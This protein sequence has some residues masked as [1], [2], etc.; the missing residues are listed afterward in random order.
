MKIFSPLFLIFY[1]C[2]ASI[3]QAQSWVKLDSMPGGGLAVFFVNSD[4]G[5]SSYGNKILKTIDGGYNWTSQQTGLTWPYNIQSINFTS[6][7]TGFA[8]G[9]FYNGLTYLGI[10]IKTVNGGQNW[11][12]LY[13]S[14]PGPLRVITCIS[15]LKCFTGGGGLYGGDFFE[16]I[17]LR[18]IDGGVTWVG[19]T[20]PQATS[21]INFPT[22]QVGYALGTFPL[23]TASNFCKSTDGG[24][25]WVCQNLSIQLAPPSF[26]FISLNFTSASIGYAVG[27]NG[28]I[29]KTIN[30]GT[31]WTV[32]NSGTT[33][34]LYSVCFVSPNTGFISGLDGAVLN[35]LNGGTTWVLQPSLT[36]Q[37]LYSMHF[38]NQNIGYAVGIG[39]TIIKYSQTVKV[40]SRSNKI[41]FNT[42]D[43]KKIKYDMLG[44]ISDLKII[45]I[46]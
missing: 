33:K 21:S 6:V 39:G 45:R 31:T 34:V 3:S 4:T 18:T 5:Y 42:K 28:S 43:I 16:N 26:T 9:Y 2:I 10:I 14:V 11:T 7:D 19:F 23:S 1:L 24:T 25:T 12:T 35:T 15:S 29:I 13:G 27:L 38:P 41:L 37:H 20:G 22:N 40:N 36:A 30:G 46:K 44:R 8:V 17:N 32:Q